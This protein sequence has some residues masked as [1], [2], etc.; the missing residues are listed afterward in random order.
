MT[1]TDT[2]LPPEPRYCH[3][4]GGNVLLRHVEEE[5]RDRLVCESCGMIHYLNPRVVAAAVP[6][7]DGAAGRPDLLLM[8]RALEPRR[9]AWTMPGG[10][11][12]VG[13]STEEAAARESEEEVGLAVEVT[14]LLGVYSR[15]AVGIV[16]V[17]YRSRALGDEPQPGV[18]A[19]D[20]RWFTA[21]AIPWD[22]LAF[23]TTLRALRD[24]MTAVER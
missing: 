3:Q 15:P 6:E 4:C 13:E 20:A 10:F 11:V 22:D 24:W 12:E 21:D 5:H 23:E 1:T 9:G 14:G 19:L 7:R 8:R 2:G 16:V 17:V 18:E